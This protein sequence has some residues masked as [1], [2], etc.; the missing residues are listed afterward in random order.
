MSN[1]LSFKAIWWFRISERLECR[2]F[3]DSHWVCSYKLTCVPLLLMTT[4]LS[5]AVSSLWLRIKDG[6]TLLWATLTNADGSA[7]LSYSQQQLVPFTFPGVVD[8]QNKDN[9][10]FPTV[11]SPVEGKV[12]ADVATYYQSNTSN[13]VCKTRSVISNH[14]TQNIVK[15]FVLSIIDK[16]YPF[17]KYVTRHKFCWSFWT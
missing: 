17:S 13:I 5:T 16:K 3:S 15:Y 12:V 4:G 9:H 7:K 10:I 11:R 14:N 8:L 6:W 1:N 2:T